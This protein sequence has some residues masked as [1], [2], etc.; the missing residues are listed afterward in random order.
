MKH[1]RF[2]LDDELAPILS[3][4]WMLPHDAAARSAVATFSAEQALADL[5]ALEARLDAT[6]DRVTESTRP[7]AGALV[8][9]H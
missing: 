5:L 4:M 8:L 7:A 9:L 2:A 3:R 1:A 6:L